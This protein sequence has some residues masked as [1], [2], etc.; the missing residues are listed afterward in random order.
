MLSRAIEHAIDAMFIGMII[1]AVAG[2]I[3]GFIVTSFI[4]KILKG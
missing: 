2:A 3:I 4:I 1:W